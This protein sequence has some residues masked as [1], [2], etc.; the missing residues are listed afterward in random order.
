[1]D[2]GKEAMHLFQLEIISIRKEGRKED[3]KKG[4]ECGGIGL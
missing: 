3:R 4:T 1:L 2:H